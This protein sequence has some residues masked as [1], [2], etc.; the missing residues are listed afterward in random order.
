MVEY[1]YILYL[2]VLLSLSLD[3]RNPSKSLKALKNSFLFI[4]YLM[5]TNYNLLLRYWTSESISI[6]FFCHYPPQMQYRVQGRMNWYGRCGVAAQ[7]VAIR[8]SAVRRSVYH[9]TAAPINI[10]FSRPCTVREWLRNAKSF[11]LSKSS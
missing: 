7:L 5:V 10:C 1:M 8:Y 2:A 6:H 9:R 4:E 3:A 11:L